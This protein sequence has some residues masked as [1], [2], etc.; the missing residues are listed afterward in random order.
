[1]KTQSDHLDDKEFIAAVAECTLDPSLFTHRAHIRLA[2]TYLKTYHF[3]KAAD[4]TCSASRNY[5]QIVGDGSKYHHTLT[6]ASVKVVDH[7]IKKSPDSDFETLLSKYPR[8]LHNF[9]LLLDQHYSRSVWDNTIAKEF[10]T[11]PDLQAF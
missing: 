3:S 6:L 4:L 5:D 1:M 8:L 9:Q 7:F 2:F 10:F 11:E